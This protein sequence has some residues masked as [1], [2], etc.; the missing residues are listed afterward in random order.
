VCSSD[1][2]RARRGAGLGAGVIERSERGALEQ[3][4]RRVG[5]AGLPFDLGQ[6]LLEPDTVA[7]GPVRASDRR[8]IS[9]PAFELLELGTD[10]TEH[11][12]GGFSGDR[13][14]LGFR[15]VLRR[16]RRIVS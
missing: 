12:T 5:A 1:L 9:T 11:D 15:H 16:H 13:D 3:L 7:A 10:R 4:D 8:R 14:C 6:A 2:V